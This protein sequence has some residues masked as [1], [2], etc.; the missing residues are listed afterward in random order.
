MSDY[1]PISL[2]NVVSRVVSKVLANRVKCI[3]PYI[4][5]D[6][7]SAF[8]PDRLITNNTAVAYEILHRLRNR[9]KGRGHMVVKL[10]ISKAYDR[11][12]WEFLRKIMLK[13]GFSARWVGLTID[14][15]SVV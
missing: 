5:S 8:V 3:L 11:V 10:Y 1:R 13:M 7:Q 4:I 6:A 9:R 12:E 15:K 2:S 14:R